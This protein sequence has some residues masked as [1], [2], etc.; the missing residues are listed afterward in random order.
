MKIALCMICKD[1]QE[2]AELLDRALDNLSPHVDGI[3]ITA[4]SKE[5]TGNVK[6]VCG[7]YN[8]NYSEFEWVNDFSAAR[9]FNFSQVPEDYNYIMWSDTDDLWESPELIKPTI[10]DSKKDAYAF[11]YVYG[12][13]ENN[14][15]NVVHKKTMIVKN[16]GTFSWKG[17]I[18]E[19]LDF[20][21]RVDV[22]FVEGVKRIHR[23]DDV[24][25]EYS[26]IR[27]LE[28]SREHFNENDP[29]SY[30]N[31]GNSLMGAGELEEAYE[32]YIK[33]LQESNSDDEKYLVFMAL[34]DL[35]LTLGRQEEAV[36][37]MRMAIGSR[38][39]LPDAYLQ[40]GGMYYRMGDLDNAESFILRGLVKKPDYHAMVVYNPRDYDYNPMMTLT[41]IYF[42]KSRPDLAIAP[43]KAC[44]EINP[45][46]DK[47]EKILKM[48][49]KEKAEMEMV[50]DSIKD[51]TEETPIEEVK[52][53]LDNVPDKIKSHPG[54]C[55]LRN[56]F[57]VKTKSSG[58]DVA[59]FCGPTSF[60]WNPDL[61]EKKGFGGSEE[62]I[63]HLSKQLAS[64]G[65]NVTVYNNC[66]IE[67]MV[68]YGVT[69]KP[70]WAFNPR[71]KWDTLVLWRSPKLADHDLNA[72]KVFVDVHDVLPVGEFTKDRLS[73]ITKVFLKSDFHRTIFENIPDEKI[74]IV[75]NGINTEE[76]K[77]M[78][79]DEKLVINTSSPE[80]SVD[81]LVKVFARIKEL[82]PEIK[83]QWAYGWDLLEDAKK[84]EKKTM[85]WVS[86][87]KKKLK[88]LGI[89]SLGKIPQKDANELY[90]KAKVLLY[91]TEFAEID[92]ISVRKAQLGGCYPIT[93]DFAALETTNA[94]GYKVHSTK[95]KDNWA[96]DK[97]QFA[98]S[99]PGQIE[100]FA[101][102]TVEMVNSDI[103]T[104]EMVEWAKGFDWSVISEKWYNEI[105]WN[106]K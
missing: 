58:K 100:E 2:E 31:L 96:K 35:C 32:V 42:E 22:F 23:T 20:N 62:A 46:N 5:F 15:P 104:T 73:K 26:R 36:A 43:I 53:V 49:E 44:L 16:D 17:E 24:R 68:R 77:P 12:F 34:G 94:K 51:I 66:G 86:R 37:N 38:P 3:F 90:C 105:V 29:R 39:D 65:L 63:I 70:Y 102:K 99:K 67:E 83:I 56:K 80:R 28:I 82:D 75:P 30:W 50:L 98:V 45:G 41:K 87:T 48:M 64:K 57:F 55:R 72:D 84:H 11:W 21:R 101:K 9:N 1:T 79:K 88:E 89:E 14:Q 40:L 91:P 103:D 71:D 81:A 10:E 54:I 74:V 52:R 92:C 93:T 25:Q 4:A 85:A 95:T 27:N 78:E 18:H 106:K 7:K 76:F 97:F 60:E 19:D 33:F 13:D 61:F 8:A 6:D 59:F 69:W 47:L